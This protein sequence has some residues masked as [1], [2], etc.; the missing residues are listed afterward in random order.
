MSGSNGDQVAYA[1][2]RLR[3]NECVDREI[4]EAPRASQ[5]NP[6]RESYQIVETLWPNDRVSAS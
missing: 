2:G 4:T 1:G 6:G 3:V 5:H